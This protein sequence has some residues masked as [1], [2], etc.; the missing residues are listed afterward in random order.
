MT[1]FLEQP[2]EQLLSCGPEPQRK[3]FRKS[4][5]NKQYAEA[6]PTQLV[7]AKK[8]NKKNFWPGCGSWHEW[9]LCTVDQWF[10]EWR[11]TGSQVHLLPQCHSQLSDSYSCCAW[12]EPEFCQ[13]A[14]IL[15]LLH[16]LKLI[17]LKWTH[18]PLS[19]KVTRSSEE[20]GVDVQRPAVRCRGKLHPVCRIF[21][22]QLQI[23]SLL[24]EKKNRERMDNSCRT[25]RLS[26]ENKE[27]VTKAVNHWRKWIIEGFWMLALERQQTQKNSNRRRAVTGYHWSAKMLL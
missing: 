2:P 6:V 8:C 13:V 12:W 21:Q 24:T 19:T 20:V 27:S 7:S 4:E 26:L 17:L 22:L 9:S 23:F 25:H 3:E 11:Q 10:A 1:V 16:F 15:I 18:L 5:R 14:T